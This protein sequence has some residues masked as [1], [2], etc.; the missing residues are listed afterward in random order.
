MRIAII[1]GGV[2]GLTLA[3]LLRRDDRFKITVYERSSRD[4][5]S[6]L[7]GF[8]VLV[9]T[10]ILD[11]L[12]GSLDPQMLELL[13]DAV[14]VQPPQGQRMCVF[15]EK[16]TIRLRWNAKDFVDARSI[17]RWKL[18]KALLYGQEDFVKFEREF[19]SYT[20]LSD[21][22]VQANFKNG[23]AIN[24][25]LLVGADGTWSRVQR[26]LVPDS[27]RETAGVTVLYFKMPLTP[28]TEAMIPFGTG[29]MVMGLRRSM[30][31]SYYK[32]IK[33]PFGPYNLRHIDP[34]E[35]F[36]MCGLGCYTNEFVDQSKHPDEMTPE[37]LK[38]ECLARMSDWHPI[39]RSLVAITVPES[40]FK[41]H[42]KT[43]VPYDHWG[44]GPVTI[45]GDAAHR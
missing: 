31:V 17:S 32:N 34:E 13:D 24:C 22:T 45:L 33:K 7:A 43:T 14:G 8:R 12:R 26:Q 23:E 11:A 5:V 18:R 15:D 40:V 10:N 3:Q 6:Q 20:K 36:L 25:D 19:V 4:D 21:G 35:S 38:D 30:I 37:E 16:G 9:N 41:A 44:T 28:E 42:I 27:S 1:G 2:G 39:F 29:C